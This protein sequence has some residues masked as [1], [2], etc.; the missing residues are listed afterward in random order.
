ML[1]IILF[2]YSSGGKDGFALLFLGEGGVVS[3]FEGRGGEGR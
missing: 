2:I 1:R 3:F